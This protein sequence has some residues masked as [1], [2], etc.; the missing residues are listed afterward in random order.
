MNADPQYVDVYGLDDLQPIFERRAPAFGV[1]LHQLDAVPVLH[2]LA[3]RAPDVVQSVGLAECWG[4]EDDP[5]FWRVLDRFPSLRELEIAWCGL[6]EGDLEALCGL[7]LPVLRLFR[8]FADDD[9]GCVERMA[10]APW[11]MGLEQVVL[12]ADVLSAKGLETLFGRDMPALDSL[13]LAVLDPAPILAGPQMAHLTALSLEVVAVD[14]VDGM[15]ARGWR[16]RAAPRLEWFGLF[17]ASQSLVAVLEMLEMPALKTLEVGQSMA[18]GAPPTHRIGDRG[19]AHIAST[20]PG[21]EVVQ[22]HDCGIGLEGA[23]ALGAGLLG[24]RDLTVSFNPLGTAGL[25]ALLP[26]LGSVRRLIVHHCGLDADAIEALR[27]FLGQFEE[28]HLRGNPI[29]ERGAQ[30][31]CETPMPKLDRL[32]LSGCHTKLHPKALY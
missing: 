10:R 21:L 32:W 11:W 1:W 15:R 7:S 2:A 4:F 13:E 22:L 18:A 8:F 24:P 17:A 27:P 16:P 28:L 3:E 19:A 14:G 31:L 29:G 6:G 5:T 20:W 12:Q 26:C 30:I 25:E 23:R 9:V